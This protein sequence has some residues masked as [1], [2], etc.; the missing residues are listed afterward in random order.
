VQQRWGGGAGGRVGGAMAVVGRPGRCQRCAAPLR[1]SCGPWCKP[2]ARIPKAAALLGPAQA[3]PAACCS[4]G[5]AAPLWP[6]R[7][8]S[9][10]WAARHH[11]SLGRPEARTPCSP[12]RPPAPFLHSPP[13]TPTPTHRRCRSTSWTRP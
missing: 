9:A 12:T 1:P 2:G 5:K 13:P 10:P 6:V 4:A 7:G 11:M 3:L 8:R